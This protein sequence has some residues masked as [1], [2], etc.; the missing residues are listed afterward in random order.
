M[1]YPIDERGNKEILMMVVYCIAVAV[2]VGAISI[3]LGYILRKRTAERKIGSAE[4]YAERIIE[5]AKRE[6]EEAKRNALLEAKDEVYKKREALEREISEKTK[7]LRAYE[8]VLHHREESIERRTLSLEKREVELQ[9]TFSQLTEKENLIKDK[10]MRAK[11]L[12]AKRVKELEEIAGMTRDEAREMLRDEMR[13]EV[14]RECARMVHDMVAEAREEAE[15]KSRDILALAI[16]RC[17]S[18]FSSETTVSLVDL[19]SEEMKGRIIGRE[20]RN[21]RALESETGVDIIIDDTPEAVVISSFDP[22]RREIAKVAIERLVKDGRIHPAIIED[23]VRKVREEI[24][25]RIVE[26]GEQ[27]ILEVGISGIHRELVKILGRLNF[28]TS[29][30]QNAL[31]HSKEV[32]YFAGVMASEL[33]CDFHLARRMGLLH[34]IGKAV[35]QDIEG[36]HAQIGAELAEKFGEKK[37]VV[38]AIACH[39]EAVEPE[40]VEAVLVCAADA[41]SATRPG[42]RHET[43]QVY[44]QR[45]KQLEDIASSFDGVSRSYAIQAGRELRVIVESALVSDEEAE[46]LAYDV[47]RKIEKEQRYPG[48]I[49]VTVIRETRAIDY[50]R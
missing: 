45:I 48:R 10:E 38:N 27:A 36:D 50:A 12:V 44:L 19:P 32:A 14:E 16:Q 23:V 49:K 1:P 40:T 4:E 18:D 37:E 34:D 35:D 39:H 31:T 43:L 30:G 29:F 33:G 25:E 22:I 6:A 46:K 24:K 42:A 3:Y 47:S 17:A 21:I 5:E 13:S 41:I 20:G 9:K 8:K 2:I 26:A 7:E 15:R 28:R 11:E